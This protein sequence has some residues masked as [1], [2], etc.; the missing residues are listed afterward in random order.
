MHARAPAFWAASGCRPYT[1]VYVHKHFHFHF[2][3]IVYFVTEV[4]ANYLVGE[5]F[6]NVIDIHIYLFALY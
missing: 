2:G 5:V 6:L 3:A 4:D 1:N